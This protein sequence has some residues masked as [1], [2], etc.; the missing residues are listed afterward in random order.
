MILFLDFDG[1]LHPCGDAYR[2]ATLFA[3]LPALEALL[4]EYPDVR[5]VVSSSWR[6]DGLEAL[7]AMF[8]DDIG[9]RIIGL[10]PIT[11]RSPDG[12]M[13]AMREQEIINW[14]TANGGLEQPWVALDDADFQF[15]IHRERLVACNPDVGFDDVACA[16]LRSHFK[17]G[18]P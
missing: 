10:T 12:Y 16:E 4:R 1:V 6:T 17:R 8:S 9:A 3:R 2:A 15:T 18:A 11:E 14:L 5:I 7:R 13:P